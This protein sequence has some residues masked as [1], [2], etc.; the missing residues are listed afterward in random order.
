M[1]KTSE[2]MLIDK[3][4][5]NWRITSAQCVIS[6]RAGI[7]AVPVSLE[8]VSRDVLKQGHL[9]MTW[10]SADEHARDLGVYFDTISKHGMN[11]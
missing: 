7:H 5:S 2:V 9:P 1:F 6:M 11:V 10:L 8:R 3:L 4:S